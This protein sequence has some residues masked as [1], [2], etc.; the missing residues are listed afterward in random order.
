M[1]STQA[2]RIAGNLRAEMARRGVTQQQVAEVL[3]LSQSAVSRRL[4]GQA[5]IS[6]DQL[7]EIT[8]RF[9]IDMASII[10]AGTDNSQQVA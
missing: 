6:I 1:N 5:P 4:L 7:F 3:G 2:P 9:G 8:E 10:F